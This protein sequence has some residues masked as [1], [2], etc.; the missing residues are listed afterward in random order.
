MK[1]D[2]DPDADLIFRWHAREGVRVRLLMWGLLATVVLTV[3]LLMFEVVYPA[4]SRRSHTTQHITILDSSSP[5]AREVIAAIADRNFLLL[6]PN[7]NGEPRLADLRPVF[8]PGFKDFQLRVKDLPET[9][10]AASVLPRL[11]GPDHAPLPPVTVAKPGTPPAPAPTVPAKVLL[12]AVPSAGLEKRP[13]LHDLEQLPS[14]SPALAE[15]DAQFR[16]AVAP[17]GRV[18]TAVSLMDESSDASAAVARAFRQSIDQLRFVPVDAPGP[19]W[20]I[21]TFR[22]KEQKPS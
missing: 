17:D 7:A 15:I 11:F 8:S 16:V 1:K 10:A 9:G 14:G 4:S 6:S 19:Q 5:K 2:E 18:V 12:V 22:W 20:G 13:V 3:W 21:I